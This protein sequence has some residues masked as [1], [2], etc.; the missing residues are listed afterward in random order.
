MKK[1]FQTAALLAALMIL[2]LL[3]LA[4]CGNMN[5]EAAPAPAETAAMPVSGGAD[6]TPAEPAPGVKEEEPAVYTVA[7]REISKRGNVMLDTSFEEMKAHDMEVGDIIT[8]FIGDESY[9][10]PVGNAYTDV[11]TGNMLC[12]FDLED[13]EVALA[14]NMGAFAVDAGVGEKQTIEEDPG[15]RW[16]LKVGE[17]G[18]ALKEKKGYL[19]EYN[20]RNLTRSNEREDYPALTDEEFANFREVAVSG[21]TEGRLYRSSTPIEPALG[22]NEYAMAAM[23][24]AGIRSVINL[25]DSAQEMRDYETYPGSYYS[26]CAVI[27][28]EM[29]Y[30]F[31]S[32]EFAEKVRDSVLFI[33]ENE[34]P[35]LVH[36]KEGKDRTGIL[37]A[38]LECCAGASAEE[39]ERDYMLT[40][41]NFYGVE[42]GDPSYDI[43]LK[44]LI[45]TLDGLFGTDGLEAADLK[46]EA[47]DYLLSIGLTQEQLD[48]L[49]TKLGD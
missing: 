42:P 26:R 5:T 11:D 27:N 25:D 43:L 29:S 21:V 23:E 3:A 6:E 10:L 36:C 38:I 31:S 28:P 49:K 13:N 45:R 18:L 33:T 20:A 32:A 8:V 47:A 41:R 39:V 16:D 48:T 19:D 15:Y 7:I 30:D 4:G 22:R 46:A 40:Y 35:Y 44:N 12:R 17:V 2:L 34:G 14:V 9:D 1:S 37:C 24:A